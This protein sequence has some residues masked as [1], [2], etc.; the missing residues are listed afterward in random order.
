MNTARFAI[1]LA[2]GWTLVL[3]VASFAC[4]VDA[5]NHT[6]QTRRARETRD[7]YIYSSIIAGL[8][9]DPDTSVRD[10]RVEVEGQVVTLRGAVASPRVEQAARR[11]ARD[12]AGVKAV[13]DF[14]TIK[15]GY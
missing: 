5:A 8:T 4:S 12:T 13:R 15:A 1:V 9:A 14:L 10:I 6:S 11:I 7:A 2:L 3:V